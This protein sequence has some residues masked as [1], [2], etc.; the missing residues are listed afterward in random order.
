MNLSNTGNVLANTNKIRMAVCFSGQARYWQECHE[1][2]KW[3]FGHEYHPV[4]NLPMEVDYFIHTWD[5]NTWRRPKTHHYVFDNVIHTDADSIKDSYKPKLFECEAWT[6]ERFPRAWDSMFYSFAK[7]LLMKRNYEL[8]ANINY[9][10]VVKARLDVVYNPLTRFPLTAINP[11]TCYTQ[12]IH[13]FPLE[14]NYSN[15]DDVIF[16]GDSPT[17]DLVGDL[18]HTYKVRHSVKNLD[19]R[20][21]LCNL[22]ETSYYGPGTL[23]HDHLTDL[24]I[25]P[26]ASHCFDY[27]VMRSTAVE[28][29]ADAMKDFP[30]VKQLWRDWYI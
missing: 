13:N 9:D 16:Y 8:D 5:T 29:G 3:F 12:S 15:F 24:G 22:D 19:L 14:F 27:A 4:F 28:A 17:M 26:E 25:R 1:N 6:Q 21:R 23:L 20:R 11:K 18:Y 7:S 2:I 10:V 30:L